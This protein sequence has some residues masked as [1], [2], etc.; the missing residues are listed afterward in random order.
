MKAQLQNQIKANQREQ[1]KSAGFFD[2]RF[3]PK[4]IQDKRRK[5]PKHKK[6]IF[7]D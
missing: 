4:V 7:N 6:L 1:Q 5:Q 3:A 2:G